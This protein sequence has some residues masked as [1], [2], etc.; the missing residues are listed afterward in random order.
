M[1]RWNNRVTGG[2]RRSPSGDITP[3]STTRRHCST[4]FARADGGGSWDFATGHAIDVGSRRFGL[5]SHPVPSAQ[6]EN[7]SPREVDIV[8]RI[9]RCER[10]PTI[11]RSLYL[12]AS[13]V[14]NHL[15]SIYRKVGVHSQV[16]LIEAL[17]PAHY[18]T[19]PEASRNRG[20]LRVCARGGC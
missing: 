8:A 5:V 1:F 6:L 2:K 4:E 17:Q 11:A 20:R 12:S 3:E 13:T 14:R 19:P 18:P 15:S 10:V 16:E 7:L 9:L